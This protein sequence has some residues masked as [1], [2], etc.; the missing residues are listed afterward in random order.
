MNSVADIK[1]ALRSLM[2][3][4][5]A[6]NLR[7]NG[8]SYKLIFGVTW[9]QLLELSREIEPSSRLA[10]ELWGNREIREC[11]LLAGLV[12]PACDFTSEDADA[13]VGDMRF[14]EEAYYTTTSLFSKIKH[15]STKAFQWIGQSGELRNLCGWVLLN[16]IFNEGS[17][18]QERS[19]D[20][21]IDQ[22]EAVLRGNGGE[23]YN[24]CRNAVLKYALIGE[25]EE[26]RLGRL[27]QLIA[28]RNC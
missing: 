8:L 25:R 21:F 7:R 28:T 5:L 13:W 24:A 18:L 6:A 14:Y 9:P 16:Q 4:E 15:R 23:V 2:N 20:E 22:A 12:M 11:R 26:K 1:V 3:G 10:V 27:L 19:E 17:P